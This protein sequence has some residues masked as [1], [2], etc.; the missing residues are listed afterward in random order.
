MIKHIILWK[1]K[2]EYSPAEKE[3]I[4]AG[5]R[6]GLEGLSG[7]IPGL[8]EVHVRT[9]G[10]SSSTAD[11]MLDSAFENADA[12]RGYSRHPAHVA[13]AETCVRPFVAVRSCFDFEI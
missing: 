3:K 1:L 11:L 8:L 4:K 9:E 5:I 7:K 10:L 13:V 12:L 2:E 6:A